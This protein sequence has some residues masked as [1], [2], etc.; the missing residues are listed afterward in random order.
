MESPN[1]NK[2]VNG[3]KIVNNALGISVTHLP[4]DK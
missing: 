3:V 2:R 4:K 1:M